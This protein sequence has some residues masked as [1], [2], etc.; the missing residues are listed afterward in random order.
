[1]R[2]NS[3]LASEQIAFAVKRLRFNNAC[4]NSHIKV[5]VIFFTS[6]FKRTLLAGGLYFSSM[7]IRLKHTLDRR[8]VFIEVLRRRPSVNYFHFLRWST[9]HFAFSSPFPIPKGGKGEGRTYL[10]RSN[11]YSTAFEFFTSSSSLWYL[12][13]PKSALKPEESF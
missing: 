7:L 6:P 3:L 11:M 10:I 12:A 5:P 9:L 8:P 4:S 13:M 2:D 1:M